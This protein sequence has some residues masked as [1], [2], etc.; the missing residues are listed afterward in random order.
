LRYVGQRVPETCNVHQPPCIKR[1]ESFM[2]EEYPYG[3]FATAFGITGRDVTK[4]SI[5][6]GVN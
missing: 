6:F 1:E 5:D 4:S 2:M 3:S